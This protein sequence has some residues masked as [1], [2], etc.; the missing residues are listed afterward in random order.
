MC[1][2][3]GTALLQHVYGSAHD[4]QQTSNLLATSG[5]GD[6]ALARSALGSDRAT[7]CAKGLAEMVRMCRRI[8]ASAADAGSPLD[9][10]MMQELV[11]AWDEFAPVSAVL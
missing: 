10:T 4:T 3:H 2:K 1:A 7:T 8:E 9:A 11:A 6:E 5:A